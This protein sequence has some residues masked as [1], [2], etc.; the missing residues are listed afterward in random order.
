MKKRPLFGIIVVLLIITVSGCNLAKGG[1]PVISTPDKNI[2]LIQYQGGSIQQANEEAVSYEMSIDLIT[3]PENIRHELRRLCEENR[4]AYGLV[5]AIIETD[6][7]FSNRMDEIEAVV[8][9]LAH[10]RDY[11]TT[12]GYPDEIVFDLLILSAQRGIEG[13]KSFITDNRA[14]GQDDYVQK[15]TAYKYYLDQ[16]DDDFVF[17]TQL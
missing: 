8:E 2:D 4:L 14:Y 11:W 16:Q 9:E 15:V 12:E 17:M 1:Q 10:Y 5:V 3:I 13:C 7:K 6:A